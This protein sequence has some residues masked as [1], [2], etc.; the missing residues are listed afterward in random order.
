[1][2][3]RTVAVIA[4][5]GFLGAGLPVQAADE[6]MT[7]ETSGGSVTVIAPETT[8]NQPDALC[9]DFPITYRVGFDPSVSNR[10]RIDG[11]VLS[12]GGGIA[13][14]VGLSGSSA[15][16]LRDD[17]RLCPS[18][19]TG[20]MTIEATATFS[21]SG[22][23]AQIRVPFNIS[24]MRTSLRITGVRRDAGSTTVRGK[25]LAYSPSK[26]RLA[27]AGSVRIRYK[28]PGRRWRGFGVT[29]AS[30]GEFKGRFEWTL[31]R[32]LPQPVLFKAQFLP[33]TKQESAT[34]KIVR[35]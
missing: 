22:S 30:G 34:S 26:G 25:V 3:W 5:V 7:F 18:D 27:G 19:D 9:E 32:R 13:A 12:S 1:M 23:S 4:V 35:K 16:S 15:T 2:T 17:V 8:W 28:K 11:Q 10:W 6:A 20:T 31:F 29:T 33:D 24:P 14:Y 21:P